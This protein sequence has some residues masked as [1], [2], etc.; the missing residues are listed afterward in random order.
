M[1]VW[2]PHGM[3]EQTNGKM[4]IWNAVSLGVLWWEISYWHFLHLFLVPFP[5]VATSAVTWQKREKLHGVQPQSLWDRGIPSGELI[6]IAWFQTR[7]PNF[8]GTNYSPW[9]YL[10]AQKKDFYK[11]PKP[12]C[13]CS[14][15]YAL[16]KNAYDTK[17]QSDRL[18]EKVYYW[19][20]L[21]LKVCQEKD[22]GAHKIFHFNKNMRSTLMQG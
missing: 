2:L 10:L 17:G 22:H 3:A 5:S 6:T 16:I 14:L 7:L 4:I 12:D 8:L 15:R 1:N 18:L 9:N 13:M 21:D 11:L 20:D 19:L